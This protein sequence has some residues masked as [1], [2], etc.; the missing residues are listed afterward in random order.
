MI[1]HH[2]ASDKSNGMR[3]GRLVEKLLLKIGEAAEATGLSRSRLYELIAAKE[4]EAVS[5]GRSRRIPMAALRDFV[6]RLRRD[7]SNEGESS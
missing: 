3:E 7:Q 5:C 1:T 2:V 4:I 6:E